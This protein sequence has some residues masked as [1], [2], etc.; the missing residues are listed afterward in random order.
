MATVGNGPVPQRKAAVPRLSKTS[1]TMKATG[2]DI[3]SDISIKVKSDK[4]NVSSSG[5]RVQTQSDVKQ[6][7]QK[8]SEN[9]LG[10]TLL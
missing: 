8:V 4:E 5:P 1:R 2:G 3:G 10:H 6:Y 9:R 7:M